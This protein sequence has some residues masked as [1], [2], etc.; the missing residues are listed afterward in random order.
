MKKVI[1]NGCFD[2]LHYGHI[3]MLEFASQIPF[4]FVYVL[5]DSDKR[6]REL[7]GPGRPVYSQ[8]ERLYLLNSL[9]Y[10]DRVDIFDSDQELIDKIKEFQP[11]IMIKGSDYQNKTILGAEHCK[12]IIFYDRIQQYSTTDK[13]KSIINRRDLY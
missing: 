6:I 3:K 1:V 11:D 4:S 5:I 2:M 12:E 8:N 13:I 10:V 7:K 9:K